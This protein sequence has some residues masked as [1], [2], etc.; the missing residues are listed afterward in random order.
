M[1]ER[2]DR[3][4]RRVDIA[5]FIGETG[6]A[7]LC[8]ELDKT[9]SSCCVRSNCKGSNATVRPRRVYLKSSARAE[10]ADASVIPTGGDRG[11][12]TV[13]IAVA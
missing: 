10:T 5:S 7:L 3:V 2:D 9:A 13:V 11:N 12:T 1:G 4:L 6:V 8:G